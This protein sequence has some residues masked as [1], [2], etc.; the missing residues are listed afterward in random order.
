MGTLPATPS[1]PCPAKF[2]LGGYSLAFNF[3][4]RL[5]GGTAPLIDTALID[6]V[7]VTLVP[8]FGL[9]FGAPRAMSA[10]DLMPDRS[11]EPL[12]MTAK[13]RLIADARPCQD[14]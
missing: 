2:R 13:N 10:L 1:E 4:L 8:A 6:A 3:G 7:A 11:L 12:F 5:G 14:L 9:M